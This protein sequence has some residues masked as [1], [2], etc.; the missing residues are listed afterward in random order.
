MM[1]EFFLFL[2]LFT[3]LLFVIFQ[4]V[5]K[6]L[7]RVFAAAAALLTLGTLMVGSLT[8]SMTEN[9]ELTDEQC[10]CVRNSIVPYG[11]SSPT[12]GPVTDPE[13][14]DADDEETD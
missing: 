5:K 2:F 1:Y 12:P 6:P 10:A 9:L 7:H 14:E 3:T 8:L 13:T 11:Y 4:R